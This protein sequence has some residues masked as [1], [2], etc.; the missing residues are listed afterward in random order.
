MFVLFSAAM[1]LMPVAVMFIGYTLIL[2]MLFTFDSPSDKMAAAG[3]AGCCSV[4]LVVICFLIYAFNEPEHEPEP[5]PE[6]EG[7]TPEAT[8]VGG[9]TN[10]RGK[11]SK[12]GR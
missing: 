7:A 1:V 2:D 6:P 10:K 5:G 12:K 11:E 3:I 9:D 8:V 4:Q